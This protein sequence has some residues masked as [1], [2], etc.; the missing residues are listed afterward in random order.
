MLLRECLPFVEYP[1]FY[2]NKPGA[3]QLRHFRNLVSCEVYSSDYHFNCQG[4]Q[5]NETSKAHITLQRRHVK[6]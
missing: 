2:F 1:R 6:S 5:R 3:A 4:K